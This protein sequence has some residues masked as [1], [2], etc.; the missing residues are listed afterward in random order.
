[1]LAASGFSPSRSK[2]FGEDKFTKCGSPHVLSVEKLALT[3]AVF[4]QE[5]DMPK[6]QKYSKKKPDY[7]KTTYKKG[8]KKSLVFTDANKVIRP[9]KKL[10][11]TVNT[12]SCPIGSAFVTTPLQLN[13]C[14]NGTGSNGRI[15][16]TIKMLSLQVKANSIFSATLGSS[17]GPSCVRYVIVYDK[18]SNAAAPSRSDVFADGVLWNSPINI[19]NRDRFIILADVLGQQDASVGQYNVA[20]EIFRKMDLNAIFPPSGTAYPNT[21]GLSLWV[22]ANGDWNDAT[23]AHFPAVQIYSRLRFTDL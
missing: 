4:R 19:N 6:G 3:R 23:S 14:S 18:Q 7:K 2:K 20:T 17:P 15:G 5:K 8:S 22:A 13:A 11:D 10:I 21:G 1:M 12:L 9:E 16:N